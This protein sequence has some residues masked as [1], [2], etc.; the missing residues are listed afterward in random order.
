MVS[1]WG[2]TNTSYPSG[3]VLAATPVVVNFYSLPEGFILDQLSNAVVG[4]CKI[5]TAW[6]VTN[7]KVIQVF[8]VIQSNFGKHVFF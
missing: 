6:R 2:H 8:Q 1:F 5:G 3:R 4:I 7:N